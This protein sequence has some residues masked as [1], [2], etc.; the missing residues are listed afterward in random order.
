[1]E[2]YGLKQ[3]DK[4]NDALASLPANMVDI[5]HTP[6]YYEVY[7]KN[8]YGE[9]VCFKYQEGD[10]IAVYPFLKRCINNL[11]WISLPTKYYDIEGVYGYNGVIS[12][13]TDF[14]F[15]QN[16][17]VAFSELCNKNNIIAEFTRFHPI[18]RNESFSQNFMEVLF[19]RPTIFIDLRKPY[20]RLFK[21]YAGKN[22]KMIRKAKKENVKIKLARSSF[23]YKN[24]IELYLSSMATLDA[25]EFYFFDKKYFGDLNEL[26]NNNLY[27]FSAWYESK[28]ICQVL[29]MRR[30]IYL[31]G[32]LSGRDRNFSKIPSNSLVFDYIVK[33]GQK[34]GGHYFHIGGGRTN[35][36]D[37]S[38][39]SFKK[40]FSADRGSFYIGKR[41]HNQQIYS[42]ICEK[43]QQAFPEKAE[44]YK[45]VLLKYWY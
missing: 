20:S 1:M 22:R 7:E 4:W 23:E 11:D 36:A 40:Y 3:Q 32:H 25:D 5:F 38:L 21:E 26:L 18:L 19:D 24:F 31:H 45:S 33:F 28:I 15:R 34:V 12:N 29:V 9:S 2:I 13:T 43:W 39:F 10:K 17:H 14:G 44:K 6:E 30:G 8:G 37:D 35:A 41:V 27:L 16:F 42:E